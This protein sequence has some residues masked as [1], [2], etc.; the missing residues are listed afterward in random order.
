MKVTRVLAAATAAGAALIAAAVPAAAA[1]PKTLLNGHV[2]VAAVSGALPTGAGISVIQ[3]CPKG[4]D[5]DKAETRAVGEQHDARLRVASTEYWPAGMVVRYRVA[6]PLRADD[7][8][9]ILTAALC[10]T[11]VA[12]TATRLSAAAKVDLRIWGPAPAQVELVDSAVVAVTDDLDAD[13]VFRTSM[14]A[15]GVNSHHASLRGAVQAVQ[16][17]IA[18]ED[19][20]DAVVAAGQTTRKVSRG[21]FVSMQNHYRFTADLNSRITVS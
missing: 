21:K 10:K 5:L 11:R 8:A 15:A 7:P 4:S 6:E 19:G 14:Q 1:S 13:Y 16:E 2:S 20:L 12:A 17:T 18:G 9:L 3:Y